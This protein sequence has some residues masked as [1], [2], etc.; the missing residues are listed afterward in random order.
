MSYTESAHSATAAV[1]SG[2]PL[3]EVEGLTVRLSVEGVQRAVLRDVSLSVRPGEAVGLVGESGSGK[4][5]TARR[6]TG[7]C[8]A[9]AEVA[10]ISPTAPTSW[11]WAHPRCAGTGTR[12]R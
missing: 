2:G 6:S 10:A 1:R 3:L 8:H 11:R 12:S 7:C 5:M 4:S 9:R